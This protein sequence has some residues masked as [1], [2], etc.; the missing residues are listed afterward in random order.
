[1]L[2]YYREKKFIC[3]DYMDV[4]IYP[5]YRKAGTRRSKAR[6]TSE[7]Q[8][9]LN[10]DN[11]R[12]AFVR[13]V[14]TN[15]TKHDIALHLTY[16]EEFLPG[17]EEE[18]RKD[19]QRFLRKLRKLYKSNSLELKYVWVCEKGERSSRVHH[20]LIIS[21]GIGRDVIEALWDKGFANTKRLK[22][23]ES[24]IS[25]LAHY[26][27]KQKLYFK[28]WNASK[29]LSHPKVVIDDY[30]YSAKKVKELLGFSE[31][32]TKY[33][34]FYNGYAVCSDSSAV[35]AA[36][37]EQNQGIYIKLQMY[38]VKQYSTHIKGVWLN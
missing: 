12:R 38:K 3:G 11:S 5:V 35:E 37:N 1:M 15:F 22:F 26:M 32:P 34:D 20:H 24:G 29:N 25:G 6:P 28:R 14:H 21:A 19:V 13:L 4:Q 16:S 30:R 36:R 17:S 10:D 23:T 18:A 2:C 8:Q 31:M 9:K 7:I 27:T 33:S